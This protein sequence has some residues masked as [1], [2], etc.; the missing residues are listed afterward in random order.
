MKLK[1]SPRAA[2]VVIA[3]LFILPLVLAWL[4]YTG[5]IAFQPG[6]TRNFGQLVQPPLPLSWEDVHLDGATEPSPATAFAEHW[7]VLHAV[8]NPCD[9]ACLRN[10]AG[11]RQVH[12]ASG[13]Q[14]SRIRLALLHDLQGNDSVRSLQGIY[15]TFGLLENPDGALWRTLQSIADQGQPSAPARGSTYLIDPLGNI[16]M[17]YAAGYDPNDLKNDLKRLLAWSKLDEQS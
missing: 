16:M 2:L 13:R 11:L 6:A 15:A 14:Q 12:L 8:P 7:L 10:I 1:L 9:D 17:F 4:M 3:A 5:T